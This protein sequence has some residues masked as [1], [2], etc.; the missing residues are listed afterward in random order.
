MAYKIFRTDIIKRQVINH[1]CYKPGTII[2]KRAESLY[3]YKRS[4]GL[5]TR[6]GAQ[7]AR[8]RIGDTYAGSVLGDLRANKVFLCTGR[9]YR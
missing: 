4:D 8:V 5:H 1:N 9:V 6:R 3:N 7:P 2:N